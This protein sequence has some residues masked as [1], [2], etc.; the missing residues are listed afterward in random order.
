MSCRRTPGF[1]PPTLPTLSSC[2]R[3]WLF[4]NHD[5]AK[6]G[7]QG[8]KSSPQ[9][10]C[11]HHRTPQS[12]PTPAAGP[13]V[14]A[15]LCNPGWPC[16][17][18]SCLGCSACVDWSSGPWSLHV[19]G[20]LSIPHGATGAILAPCHASCFSSM[21]CGAGV[22]PVVALMSPEIWDRSG[23]G[24]GWELPCPSP[25]LVSLLECAQRSSGMGHAVQSSHPR[26]HPVP[27]A[28]DSASLCAGLLGR[29]ASTRSQGAAE[30]EGAQ[31]CMHVGA[32]AVSSSCRER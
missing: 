4:P 16:S 25:L 8:W 13:G 27:T 14:P 30:Q 23:P 21:R 5:G 12:Q 6:G 24:L 17:G 15:G 31:V 11:P 20:F 10:M 22:G 18:P 32:G 9:P 26:E 19:H 28:A 1:K 29:A 3:I 7:E 2:C